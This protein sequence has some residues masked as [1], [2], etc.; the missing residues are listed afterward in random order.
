MLGAGLSEALE[1][2]GVK[3]DRLPTERGRALLMQLVNRAVGA[4][5]EGKQRRPKI[6]V[7]DMPSRC[8]GAEQ[9]ADWCMVC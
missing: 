1:A 7:Y 2:A 8:E 9:Q 4:V 5:P 3:M 6:F